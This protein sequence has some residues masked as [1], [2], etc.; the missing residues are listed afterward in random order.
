MLFGGIGSLIGGYGVIAVLI[1]IT[2]NVSMHVYNYA[3][4]FA[5]ISVIYSLSLAVI[6]TDLKRILC[7][8]TVCYSAIA[9]VGIFSCD[10][11]GFIGG[12]YCL[13]AN[14]VVSSLLFCV[15]YVAKA[16][17][18][19]RYLSTIVHVSLLALVATPLLPF[20]NSGFF[21]TVGLLHKHLWLGIILCSGM[22]WGMSLIVKLIYE[23]LFCNAGGPKEISLSKN[24]LIY[25][26]PPMF[27]ILLIGLFPK[28]IMK[29]L[30]NFEYQS[31]FTAAHFSEGG[32]Q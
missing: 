21:I 16:R 4:Y 18:E 23:M 14:G 2:K 26:L 7:C 25:L 17:G 1:P 24:E 9:A 6:Q 15:M 3:M 13:L 32:S 31:L 19:L 20:F 8:V 28:T 29:S 27:F 30:H 11:N 22:I 12:V 5:M 10:T